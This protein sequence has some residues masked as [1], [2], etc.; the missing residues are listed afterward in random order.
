MKL[1][2]TFG[3]SHK[4]KINNLIFD[5][6][7]VCVIECKSLDEGYEIASKAFGKKWAFLYIDLS[8]INLHFY[9]RGLVPL[10]V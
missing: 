8:C 4:H 5:K 7:C 3:Q 2:I 10:V 6:D 1:Y 9:H